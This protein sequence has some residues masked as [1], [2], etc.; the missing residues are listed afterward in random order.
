MNLAFAIGAS[1]VL[2]A[3]A[4]VH[5]YWAVGG[6]WPATVRAELPQ[7]V[8]GTKDTK[9]PPRGVTLAVAFMIFVAALVPL[10]TT[11]LLPVTLPCALQ[12]LALW[13]L[14]LVFLVR[15]LVTYTPLGDRYS[16]VE[17]FRTLNRKYY[18]PLCVLLGLCLSAIAF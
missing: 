5:V 12:M 14:I 6:V 4:A 13:G 17:P 7:T 9:M 18:S 1:G 2:M 3:I 10:V 8:V 15:G 16:V 11:G